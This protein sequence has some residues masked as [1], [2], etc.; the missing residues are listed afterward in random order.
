IKGDE[1][2]KTAKSLTGFIKSACK[3]EK[4]YVQRSGVRAAVKAIVK[5]SN[6]REIAESYRAMMEALE[7][8]GLGGDTAG[9]IILKISQRATGKEEADR[10]PAVIK[11]IKGFG[12]DWKRE[13]IVKD[14]VRINNALAVMED[15]LASK[16][17]RLYEGF[18]RFVN[19][20]V[21]KRKIKLE[22]GRAEIKY[23]EY[24]LGAHE[25]EK[26]EIKKAITKFEEM[27][28][29]QE[30]VKVYRAFMQEMYETG[31]R[32]KYI[33]NILTALV[34]KE[35]SAD[36][37]NKYLKAGMTKKL[38]RMIEG[39]Y[40]KSNWRNSL[41]PDIIPKFIKRA[42]AIKVIDHIVSLN[43]RFKKK[44]INRSDVQ[45]IVLPLLDQADIQ[46]AIEGIDLILKV[47][48]RVRSE[49][50]YIER[51]ILTVLNEKKEDVKGTLGAVAGLLK[52]LEGEK[53]QELIVDHMLGMP[54]A[55]EA[56]KVFVK[57]RAKKSIKELIL[58][59]ESTAWEERD[60]WGEEKEGIIVE[61]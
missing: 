55:K 39:L 23:L 21:G 45:E 9:Y 33:K 46:K 29:P 37:V 31:I 28:N 43:K 42:D 20:V 38:K 57:D 6:T 26:S 10:I 44:G 11:R 15:L 59:M 27:R 22:A 60:V 30:A 8:E 18:V 24:V 50:V 58:V 53:Y 4:F 16:G 12:V 19:A 34:Q 61:V 41:L 2:G 32:F 1:A 40:D 7:A 51:I 3:E 13:E 54:K 5:K 56:M 47:N 48:K 36:I 49:Y 52:S 25:V 14:L 35:R 17:D